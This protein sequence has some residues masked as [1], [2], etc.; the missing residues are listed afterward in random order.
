MADSIFSKVSIESSKSKVYSSA[1]RTTALIRG[2]EAVIEMLESN[3]NVKQRVESL[4]EIADERLLTGDKEGAEYVARYAFGILGDYEY[5][6]AGLPDYG[7][8]VEKFD[9]KKISKELFDVGEY[10][11]ALKIA[12]L[13]DDIKWFTKLLIKIANKIDDTEKE[14]AVKLFKSALSIINSSGMEIDVNRRDRYSQ[15]YD[16]DHPTITDLAQIASSFF[17]LGK[18][19]NIKTLL[20][21]Y[22]ELSKMLWQSTDLYAY[23]ALH[24]YALL[25]EEEAIEKDVL[26]LTDDWQ[27]S[28]AQAWLREISDLFPNIDFSDS[29]YSLKRNEADCSLSVSYDE[30]A[31]GNLGLCIVSDFEFAHECKISLDFY[32]KLEMLSDFHNKES[33]E[34]FSSL[35]KELSIPYSNTSRDYGEE[36]KWCAKRTML[37]HHFIKSGLFEKHKYLLDEFEEF[38]NLQNT[39]RQHSMLYTITDIMLKIDHPITDIMDRIRITYDERNY[40]SER[41]NSNRPKVIK[42]LTAVL[43]EYPDCSEAI[44]MA[45]EACYEYIANNYSY[46]FDVC[47]K[48]QK[49]LDVDLGLQSAFIVALKSRPWYSLIDLFNHFNV[50]ALRKIV[51][52]NFNR[53]LSAAEV[54]TDLC[55]ELE[56]LGIVNAVDAGGILDE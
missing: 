18:P 3:T 52:S 51:D 19:E 30:K 21:P 25:G 10:D 37:I 55:V 16:K 46:D 17:Y 31:D 4:C 29:Q 50:A 38:I 44:E 53:T 39:S 15:S 2:H 9:R 33:H 6:L 13:S 27:R 42:A 49:I 47:I 36:M 7:V 12:S 22:S 1:L 26:A 24:I 20:P 11:L 48:A 34:E 43:K 41:D 40:E 56:K 54:K 8:K 14:K 5:S 45:K 32:K 23:E 35:L 28:Y